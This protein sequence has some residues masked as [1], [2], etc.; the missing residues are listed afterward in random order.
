MR[1]GGRG[2]HRR[3]GNRPGRAGHR[4]LERPGR[5]A[6][7]ARKPE[8]T[9][10]RLEVE[11]GG[12]GVVLLRVPERAVVD[13]VD[14]HRA[15][16]APP[17][18]AVHLA[19]GA[20][21]PDVLGAHEPERV[22]GEPARD[23]DRGVHGRARL[24]VSEGHVAV[25]VHRDR[26]HPS[27]AVVRGVGPLLVDRRR[28]AR[29]A[30]LVPADGRAA[31][32]RANGVVDDERLVVA[33][34]AIGQAV[35]DALLQRLEQLRRVELRHALA[36]ESVA[37]GIDELRG[38]NVD[39]PG[40][41]AVARR[42][43]VHVE[44][45]LDEARGPELE[46]HEVVRR[47]GRRRRRPVEVRRQHAALEA[48]VEGD[49]SGRSAGEH[50]ATI[51][52]VGAALER[53]VRPEHVEGHVVRVGPDAELAVVAEEVVARLE[54]VLVIR[55]RGVAR[56]R[57]GEALVEGAGWKVGQR[58][59]RE[60][61][62]VGLAVVA[63]ER[64]A[65]VLNLARAAEAGPEGVAGKRTEDDVAQLVVDHRDV[66]DVLDVV[67][68][69]DVALRV[70]RNDPKTDDGG[71]VGV[72]ETLELDLLLRLREAE[73]PLGHGVRRRP[74]CARA[75]LRHDVVGDRAIRA[76]RD[77]PDRPIV[78]EA[79]RHAVS[80]GESHRRGLRRRVVGGESDTAGQKQARSERDDESRDPGRG[81]AVHPILQFEPKMERKPGL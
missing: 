56:R 17:A 19:A 12:R 31:G 24:R 2:R 77:G 21:E 65:V 58:E 7:A 4:A 43:P 63:H 14:G 66:V 57:D 53:V 45:P 25:S 68:R 75:P 44:L 74:R 9:D 15:V 79:R 29:A 50:R 70:G 71:I 10:A 20:G 49:H 6:R 28:G 8:R 38:G 22:A 81:V 33:E 78:R 35:H 80:R 23:A 1:T 46:R 36:P 51:E 39:R 34:V 48:R 11:T 64:I 60:H 55:A 16:V 13:R 26:T 27:E 67:V 72:G 40:E 62:A 59:L 73:L 18:V 30:D 42:R 3:T 32:L 41:R 5:A 61:P 54:L 76:R 47:A 52:R 69:A 37:D